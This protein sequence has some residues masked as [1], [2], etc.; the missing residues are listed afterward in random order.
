MN[1]TADRE[2]APIV[3]RRTSFFPCR[4]ANF[5][6]C[7]RWGGGYVRLGGPGAVVIN[8]HGQVLDLRTGEVRLDSRFLPVN[9]S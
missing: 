8:S 4:M 2:F 5:F 3:R 6:D 7:S 9:A 1:T